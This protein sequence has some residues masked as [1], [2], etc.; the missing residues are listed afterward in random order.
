MHKLYVL[1]EFVRSKTNK[2]EK[3]K[4]VKSPIN[5]FIKSLSYNRWNFSSFLPGVLLVFHRTNSHKTYIF[6]KNSYKAYLICGR[7]PCERDVN[8]C[9]QRV[10]C[11]SD[12]EGNSGWLETLTEFFLLLR[13]CECSMKQKV[14]QTT[15]A[16]L[17]RLSIII[18]LFVIFAKR[19]FPTDDL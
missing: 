16:Y 13:I 9:R 6:H 7:S 18:T 8:I 5:G 12:C 2:N 4:M 3:V 15:L 1:C 17:P 11:E 19:S 14:H 10:K